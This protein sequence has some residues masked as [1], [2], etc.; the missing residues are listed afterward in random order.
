MKFCSIG[1]EREKDGVQGEDDDTE[2]V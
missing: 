1:R 2:E